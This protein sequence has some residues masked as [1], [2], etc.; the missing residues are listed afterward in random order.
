[1]RSILLLFPCLLGSFL[2][3]SAQNQRGDLIADT[4][5]HQFTIS[6]IEDIYDQQ[7]IPYWAAPIEYEVEVYKIV[8]KTLDVWGQQLVNA[9][10]AVMIPIGYPC[11]AALINYNHGTSV[12]KNMSEFEQ[13][14]IIGVF[15]S[16]GGFVSAF[17][18]YLG[19]GESSNMPH[20]YVMKDPLATDAIDM[21]RAT[22]SFCTQKGIGLNGELFVTGVSEGGYTTMAVHRAIEESYASEFQVTAAAPASGPYILS[23]LTTD[24]IL[25]PLSPNTANLSYVIYSYNSVHQVIPDWSEIFEA[26]YDSIIPALWDRANP[27]ASLLGSLPQYATEI[28]V[29]SALQAFR[30]DPNHPMRL[31][32]EANNIYDWVPQAPV[33]M[34]YCPNDEEIPYMNALLTRDSMQMNGAASVLAIEAS[35]VAGH[36]DCH[37]PSLI[38]AL[39]WFKDLRTD[40]SSTNSDPFLQEGSV[41]VYPNPFDDVLSIE[42]PTGKY[43]SLKMIDIHGRCVHEASISQQSEIRLEGIDFMPGIYLLELIGDQVH[44][45]P[46]IAK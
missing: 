40:C 28:L 33:R 13:D 14:A 21:I 38:F 5:L 16:T 35:N 36:F 31:L 8:Y 44:R 7:G 27:N 41:R 2:I 25:S 24:S 20:G 39:S 22:Q 29:D 6:E 30:N 11:D 34:Y 45:F 12:D 17:P 4:L 18:D 3:L 9:S 42:L 32:L 43:S 46:V 10:G 26:P 1:M 15:F 23:P 37:G 19:Y